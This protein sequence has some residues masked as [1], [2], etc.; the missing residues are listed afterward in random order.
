MDFE[1]VIK[2]RYSVRYFEN[3]ILSDEDI[4]YFFECARLAPSEKMLNLINHIL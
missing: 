1:N 2:T 3:K 4:N